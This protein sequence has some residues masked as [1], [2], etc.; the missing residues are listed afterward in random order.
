MMEEWMPV[1][2]TVRQRPS[3]AFTMVVN[4]DIPDQLKSFLYPTYI[5]SL[6][7]KTPTPVQTII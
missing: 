7:K 2:L 3:P 4:G 5:V 1:T 6:E